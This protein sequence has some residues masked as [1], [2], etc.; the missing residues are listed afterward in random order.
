MRMGMKG[1]I[2]RILAGKPAEIHITNFIPSEQLSSLSSA[3]GPLQIFISACPVHD[4]E[5]EQ[6]CTVCMV[7]DYA[8]GGPGFDEQLLRHQKMENIETLAGGVAHE[9]NN[10][11]TGIKGLSDLIKEESS[12]NPDIYEYAE[13]IQESI[14]RGAELVQN[15][16]A[17]ARE[18][19]LSLRR[20]QLSRY[21]EQAVPMFK[22]QV[23]K[24]ARLELKVEAD[25]MLMLDP[26][27]MNQAL[28]GILIN[29]A[30]AMNGQGTARISTRPLSADEVSALPLARD[31][32]W[33][34]IDVEDAGPGI[35]EELIDRVTEPFFTTKE[36]GRATGLGLAVARRIVMTHNGDLVIGRSPELG[37]ARVSIILPLERDGVY[38]LQEVNAE[39]A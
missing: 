3:R 20:M 26:H 36:R 10:I 14:S 17:Y 33:V 22:L 2:D 15:L 5:T 21:L 31:C 29:A 18:M 4:P 28:S 39:K 12:G 7:L 38:S 23:Q 34:R 35:P 9:F 8:A 37:G 24:R 6:T 25:G 30:D 16:T 32:E 13:G 1:L 19:P 27:R 11:F